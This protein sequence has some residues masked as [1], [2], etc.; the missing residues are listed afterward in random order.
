MTSLSKW[1]SL[2]KVE[3]HRHLDCSIRPATLREL[4]LAQGEDVPTSREDFAARYLVK[5]PMRDLE[6]VLRKFLAAQKALSSEAVLTRITEE[7]IMDAVAENIR[8][9]ELRFAPTF[10]QEGHPSLSFEAIH[11]AIVCGVDRAVAES[12]VRKLPIAVGL[13]YIAQRIKPVSVADQ[14][15]SFAIEAHRDRPDLV[16]GVDLADNEDGFDS[17]PFAPL[18][19]RCKKA[20]LGVTIH[21]GE[22]PSSEA[23]SRVLR[24]VRELGADRIG[25]GLQIVH[26]LAVMKEIAREGVMLEICPTSN[27]LTS[28]ATSI[29][30]HPL[31]RLFDADV[32]VCLNTDDPGVFD[33]NLTHEYDAVADRSSGLGLGEAEFRQMN[34]WALEAS[35]LDSKMLSQVWP[36]V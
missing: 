18:F 19:Q 15:L 11:R 23:P 31:K 4:L 24:A 20:G 10:I 25:H 26:D 22:A 17:T 1:H 6:S 2:P 32:R 14:V 28:A 27:V 21:A 34:E 5:E 12:R 30:K 9:L 29:S 33:F 13:I 8:V 36:H 3:L 35:F 7:C 16:V